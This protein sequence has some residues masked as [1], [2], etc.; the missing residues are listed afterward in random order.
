MELGAAQAR[1]AK[2][3][4]P[5][6][7][8]IV[9]FPNDRVIR[10]KREAAQPLRGGLWFYPSRSITSSMRWATSTSFRPLSMAVLRSFS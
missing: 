4:P 10:E 9:P 1:D 7:E 3:G 5:R 6:S 2:Q 8:G